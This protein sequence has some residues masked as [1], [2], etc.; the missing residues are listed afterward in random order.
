VSA[1]PLFL[2]V[3]GT[4]MFGLVHR[5]PRQSGSLSAM[6]CPPWGWDEV[7]SY[8]SRRQWAELL[9]GQGVTTLRFD[10]PGTGDSG[11]C[12]SDGD[13]VAA[14]VGAV[15]TGARWLAALPGIESVLAIG[16]GIGGLLT[17][18]AI[19]AG[20][21]ID[22]LVLWAT[23]AQGRRYIRTLKAFAGTQSSRVG[24]GVDGADHGSDGSLD[25][26]GFTLHAA[27]VEALSSLDVR[28]AG[29]GQVRR[30][31]VI[32]QDGLDDGD[33]VASHL[34][35]LGVDVSRSR[36]KGWADLVS[37]PEHTKLAP[38]VIDEVATWLTLP[39]P[40]HA[41]VLPVEAGHD[42]SHAVEPGGAVV[43]TPFFV[44]VP[45]GDLLA[46][47]SEPGEPRADPAVCM[48]FLNAGAVRR[49]GPNRLWVTA[50]RRWA[51]RGVPS[52]RVDLGGIGDGFGDSTCPDGVADL[53]D[54]ARRDEVR[55]AIDA[56]LERWPAADVVLVGL[57]AGGYWAFRGAAADPRVRATLL[58]NPGALEWHPDTSARHQ[59]DRLRKLRHPSQW[60]RIL[61]GEVRWRTMKVTIRGLADV[62]RTMPA[63]RRQRP[64]ETIDTRESAARDLAE[65]NARGTRVVLAFS[66]DEVLERELQ[67][68][69][70][71]E[72]AAQLP[73]VDLPRLP[74]FDHTLRPQSAQRAALDLIDTTVERIAEARGDAAVR[75]GKITEMPQARP[76]AEEKNREVFDRVASSYTD[77]SLAPAERVLLARLAPSLGAMDMLELGVGAGRTAYTFAPL[78]RR[79]VGLDYA[80]AMIAQAQALLSGD[81]NVELVLGDARDLSCVDGQFDLVT[82]SFNGIDAVSYEDRLAVLS[83][84]ASVLRPGGWFMFSTH[85]THA[86]PLSTKKAR[87]PRRMRSRPYRWYAKLDDVRYWWKVRDVNRTLRLDEVQAQGWTVVRN[88]GHNFHIDDCYVE[89][90][91]QVDV[92]KA[93]GFEAIE[94]FDRDGRRVTAVEP[95]DGPWLH[96]LCRKP[97]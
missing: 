37:H 4:P 55:S 36:V 79:Y 75:P 86:L 92:L 15:D 27:T 45:S 62:V 57:C 68:S 52:L 76:P 47:A 93:L 60:R 82:F 40:T 42:V 23:P 96:Y 24:L 58:L 28:S 11:G 17:S 71:L 31:L 32:A 80:P 74:G 12:A 81:A 33:L 48:V 89:P 29:A 66:G 88:F 63:R 59:A 21:P 2:D 83:Q 49:I 67:R 46:I 84:V 94:L 72:L 3:G 5:P 7:A 61:R 16:L 69:G 9:A 50:A 20:A 51:A 43:E 91:H 10:L 34:E 1:R 85:S 44:P 77:L 14:W 39:E 13:Q 87:S 26:N 70:V 41:S 90:T 78:V 56:A 54:G 8:R 64:Q 30:A 38:A 22:E 95:G 35:Q 97:A 65:L 18:T 73:L 53:Y 19:A 6:I 25:V